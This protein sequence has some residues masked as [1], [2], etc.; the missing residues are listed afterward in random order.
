MKGGGIE[1]FP[2]PGAANVVRA[3]FPVLSHRTIGQV[4]Q[5]SCDNHQD[6]F[7]KPH[8]MTKPKIRDVI[9]DIL[10]GY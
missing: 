10:E 5:N 7:V 3:A 2:G 1:L 4:Q 6:I 8:F 9:N